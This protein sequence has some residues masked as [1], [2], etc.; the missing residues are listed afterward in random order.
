[1]NEPD[2]ASIASLIGDPARSRMLLALMG[3]SALTATELALEAEVS[4]S[5]ASSHL[6]KLCAAGLIKPRQQG[7][8]RYFQIAGGDVAELIERLSGLARPVATSGAVRGPRDPALRK[9]RVCYDHLAGE[10]AVALFDSLL[11]QEYLDVWGGGVAVSETGRRF[12]ADFGI[13][14]VSLTEKRRVL[15]RR[16]LDWSV[17]RDHLAGSLAAAILDRVLTLRWAQRDPLSRTLHFSRAGE[18]SFERELLTPN[19]AQSV[20]RPRA[21]VPANAR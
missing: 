7:R 1:M 12:F 8:H 19:D 18:R 17:R 11:S 16:C 2:I 20:E 13:D 15:C 21:V 10:M 5:T 14:L 9:A 4:P 6:K 3:G